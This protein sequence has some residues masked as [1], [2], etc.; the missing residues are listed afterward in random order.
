MA[1]TA[2]E[3]IERLPP[4]NNPRR[5]LPFRFRSYKELMAGSGRY[6][7]LASSLSLSV[8]Y[9]LKA[10]EDFADGKK[11]IAL[12][13]DPSQT[14]TAK[15]KRN[16]MWDFANDQAEHFSINTA[17]VEFSELPPHTTQLLLVSVY[18]QAE[19]FLNG[20]RYELRD[21]GVEWPARGEHV[22]LLEYTLQN[23]PNGLD[24]N[25]I[26]IGEERYDLFEYYRLMRNAFVHS[27]LS[28]AKLAKHFDA[29]APYRNLMASEYGVDAPNPFGRMKLD[30]YM[31]FTRLIKYIA[32][33]ICRIGEPSDE[34]LVKLIEWKQ[35]VV[36]KP[37]KVF[38][39]YRPS[40]PLMRAA[41]SKWFH[42]NYSLT[43]DRRPTALDALL[44][45][46]SRFPNKRTRRRA[47]KASANE[48]SHGTK[49]R[50][51]KR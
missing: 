10:A 51:A 36:G 40:K 32:T 34:A 16:A 38:L 7:A 23:L 22:P 3:K 35:G 19:S 1:K 46:V 37:L 49:K 9:F 31:L 12:G 45:Y 15:D 11:T 4:I 39:K 25:K 26:M 14:F 24:D 44:T 48:P 6:D 30:D 13:Q 21:M 50:R 47:I 41:I 18:Q 43:L 20:V 5:Q 42:A 2:K 28:S 17:N 27:P 29:V 8:Q 33:D